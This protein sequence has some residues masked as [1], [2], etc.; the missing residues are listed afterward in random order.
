MTT[1]IPDEV[2]FAIGLMGAQAS[3]TVRATQNVVDAYCRDARRR[4]AELAIIR[5]QI[6]ESFNGPYMPMPDTVLNGLLPN[7]DR[8]YEWL[9]EHYG[10]DW[11]D[12]AAAF[13]S[14]HRCQECMW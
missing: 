1:E 13:V 7:P 12:S 11:T 3:A 8:V 14:C 10:E 4:Q 5:E 9:T 2:K 6:T